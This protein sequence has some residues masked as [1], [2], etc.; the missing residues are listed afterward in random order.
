MKIVLKFNF[1]EKEY[2]IFEENKNFKYG[3]IENNKVKTDI[4]NID[5]DIINLIIYKIKPS[6]K[7]IFYNKIILNNAIYYIYIDPKTRFKSFKPEPNIEDLIILNNNYNNLSPNYHNKT[8]YKNKKTNKFIKIMTSIGNNTITVMLLSSIAITTFFST[9]YDKVYDVDYYQ[10]LESQITYSISKSISTNPSNE[11]IKQLIEDAL[12]KNKSLNEKEKNIILEHL[13]IFYDNKKYIDFENVYINIVNMK[14]KY[15]NENISEDNPNIKAQWEPESMKIT[16]GN[17]NSIDDINTSIF[18]HE[19]CHAITKYNKSSSFLTESL[20]SEINS[21]YFEED[22]SYYKIKRYMKALER[23]IGKEPLKQYYG[24]TNHNI[25]IDELTKIIDDEN[26]AFCFLETLEDYYKL[27]YENYISDHNNEELKDQTSLKIK[28]Y[29]KEYYNAKYNKNMS[30]DLIMTYY[31]N[32]LFL[33]KKIRCALNL[34]PIININGLTSGK[35]IKLSMANTFSNEKTKIYIRNI[36]YEIS[37][38]DK[39]GNAI[40]TMIPNEYQYVCDLDNLEFD[41][42]Y[43]QNNEDKYTNATYKTDIYNNKYIYDCAIAKIVPIIDALNWISNRNDDIIIEELSKIVNDQNKAILLL[44]YIKEDQMNNFIDLYREFYIAKYNKN[45]D[46]DLYLLSIFNRKE[47]EHI[48]REKYNLNENTKILTKFTVTN[49][50]SDFKI[51]YINDRIETK[52][53]KKIYIIDSVE[54]I[55]LV[56]TNEDLIANKGVVK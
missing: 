15:L 49:Y 23:I 20:N 18:T 25:I 45:I 41:I 19:F 51:L 7:N 33:E 39:D 13:E 40:Y 38:Y 29:L 35:E 55:G 31:T 27:C 50:N 24:I 11:E 22:N 10:L 32:P 6:N 52:D 8:N 12:S 46:E 3:Y 56:S 26:K 1:N 54:T 34:N 36:E 30:N 43:F 53:N 28:D 4:T 16:I 21:Y 48:I 42:E 5:K 14:I 47:F 17:A 37:G 44:K 2:C 9:I